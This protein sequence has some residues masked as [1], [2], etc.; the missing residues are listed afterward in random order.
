MEIFNWIS[1]NIV[2]KI[3]SVNQYPSTHLTFDPGIFC[4]PPIDGHILGNCKPEFIM[5][6]TI[7]F[8]FEQYKSFV[9]N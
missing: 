2:I 9:C 6:L 8:V 7:C 1:K 5:L 4:I 3:F